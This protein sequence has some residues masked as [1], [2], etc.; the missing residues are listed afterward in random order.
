MVGDDGNAWRLVV[1]EGPCPKRL[2]FSI[3]EGRKR[4]T[5]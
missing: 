2:V 4:L 3:D 5:A 1:H